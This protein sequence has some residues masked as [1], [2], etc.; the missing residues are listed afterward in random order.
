[1]N[2]FFTILR[3]DS[4]YSEKDNLLLVDKVLDGDSKALD[5]LVDIHQAF[6]QCSLKN[7]PQQ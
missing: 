5:K 7:D 3:V 4:K 2:L 6:I 1:M